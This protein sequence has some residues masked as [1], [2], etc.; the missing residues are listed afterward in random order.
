M[1]YLVTCCVLIFILVGCTTVSVQTEN[2]AKA[3]MAGL[4]SYGW[5][6]TNTPP[7]EN[8][9]VNN[10][11]V[12]GLVRDAVEMSLQKK[13]YV[14]D[15]SGSPDFLITWFG[16]I[17]KKVKKESID[18]FYSTYGYGSVASQM[19]QKGKDSGIVKKYEEG[20]IL[21]DIL[22]HKTHSRIWRGSGT[23]RLMKE[24]NEGAAVQ[25]IN[26]VVGQIF[27]DFPRSGN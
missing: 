7:G 3:N 11:E 27:K 23:N 22:D 26:R 8:V 4:K 13:G 19:D 16:A 15:D 17:E 21:V 24:M 5:L 18:H 6:Q 12:V 14:K 2:H 9:R 1:K 20:T 25:Y 10:P